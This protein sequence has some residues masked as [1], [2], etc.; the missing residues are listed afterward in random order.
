MQEGS[1]L[2][3]FCLS[4]RFAH[5]V[6]HS[7]CSTFYARAPEA[8]PEL[9]K[10]GFVILGM[11]LGKLEGLWGSRAGRKG[12]VEDGSDWFR[13]DVGM[14]IV[15]QGCPHSKQGR[16]PPAA[17]LGR[18]ALPRLSTMRQYLSSLKGIP[19]GRQ[20]DY[21]E[22][23]ETQRGGRRQLPSRMSALPLN[24]ESQCDVPRAQG[25]GWGR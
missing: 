16:R 18:D 20:E 23:I 22:W 10:L 15:S 25:R 8:D 2:V 11:D 13:G 1:Q 12:V 6:T 4:Q 5:G 7:G 24:A 9:S 14:E 19:L 3:F 17:Q 21:Q